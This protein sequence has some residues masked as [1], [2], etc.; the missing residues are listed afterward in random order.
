MI[1]ERQR[2]DE[3]RIR[4]DL[5]G[6]GF[7]HDRCDEEGTVC[8][9]GRCDLVDLLEDDDTSCRRADEHDETEDETYDI[10]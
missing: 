8:T 10:A 3:L 6:T 2:G 1:G 9:S 5:I 4:S 7:R